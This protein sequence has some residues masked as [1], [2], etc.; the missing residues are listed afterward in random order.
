MDDGW[1]GLDGGRYNTIW[2][3]NAADTRYKQNQKQIEELN[4][5]NEL[6]E[7]KLQEERENAEI[8]AEAT[9]KAENDRYIK[10]L[11]IEEMRQ[12]LI[13]EQRYQKI[14]DKIGMAYDDIMAFKNYLEVLTIAET[15]EYD[16]IISKVN[17]YKY[18]DEIKSINQDIKNINKK[19]AATT[20]KLEELEDD[21]IQVPGVTR[22]GIE[23]DDYPEEIEGYIK[24][25]KDSIPTV[26]KLL[27]FVLI[28][29][30]SLGIYL[31]MSKVLYISYV[32]FGITGLISLYLL[33]R[34]IKLK[35]AL[36]KME[37]A[38]NKY[39]SKCKNLNKQLGTL[40]REKNKK[41]KLYK[42]LLEKRLLELENN[43]DY[44]ALMPKYE[45]AKK[46]KCGDY[47]PNEKEFNDFR[48]T[49]Y[50]EEME[51]NLKNLG[52]KLNRL[53]KNNIKNIGTASDYIDY[54]NEILANNEEIFDE[55]VDP[56]L[57][58]VIDYVV[59]NK[60]KIELKIQ[61]EIELEIHEEFDITLKR[62]KN[63]MQQ[64]AERG[65]I[66]LKKHTNT[67]EVY[68]TKESWK[69]IKSDI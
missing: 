48:M 43:L 66:L 42:E 26:R 39:T 69:E 31:K 13:E 23:I 59:E 38:L 6:A 63:I 7:Q 49:H 40:K 52:F 46:A 2:E 45:E 15:E 32:T 14:C 24:A 10:N 12:E 56:L 54:I 41:E 50:N 25:N 1:V 62:V 4:K 5:A 64:M 58:Q 36:K 55:D 67:I 28:A 61:E 47:K 29:G 27:Y 44:Q 21:N 65:I 53:S 9:R 33:D 60:E 3:R 18:N 68:I 34:I 11:E 35:D 57:Y 37:K 17:N 51:I 30:I 22:N 8:I 16:K 20:T 19:I